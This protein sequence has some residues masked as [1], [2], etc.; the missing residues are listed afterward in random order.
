MSLLKE[1]YSK[2]KEKVPTPLRVLFAGGVGFIVLIW[3]ISISICF[4]SGA[5][6][7]TS[8][9]DRVAIENPYEFDENTIYDP[10]NNIYFNYGTDQ[11][12]FNNS[13]LSFYEKTGVQVYVHY[14]DLSN[15]KFI[16]YF[17]SNEELREYCMEQIHSKYGDNLD[18]SVVIW[19]TSPTKT[20][21]E[22][23]KDEYDY[24]SYCVRSYQYIYGSK[25]RQI[26]DGEGRDI[27]AKSIS[28]ALESYHVGEAKNAFDGVAD[29]LISGHSR[30]IHTG[31]V[32]TGIVLILC[33]AGIIVFAYAAHEK[34]ADEE[35]AELERILNTP[36]KTL[37]E[38]E[39]EEKEAKY[40][41]ENAGK[42]DGV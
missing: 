19:R 41:K 9:H 15:E 24:D 4:G 25:T 35:E 5:A 13:L 28:K 30:R 27:F 22:N 40:E 16:N 17:N 3:I 8:T 31:F 18:Y 29:E 14:F 20:Y 21:P 2:Y 34:K 10:G 39:L 42:A 6:S 37:V 36:T 23:P 26:F 38:Q 1:L 7:G 33:A 32:L 12:L 11:A